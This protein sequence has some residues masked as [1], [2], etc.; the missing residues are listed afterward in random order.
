MLLRDVVATSQRVAETTRR[1]E[2][3]DLLAT[4][5]KR[6]AGDEVE[7]RR[8]HFLS[9]STRQAALALATR[10]CG[11]PPR[12]PRS[13]QPWKS[14]MS[15]T[16][17]ESLTSVRGRGSEQQKTWVAAFLFVRATAAEQDFL[18]GLLLGTYGKARL[19]CDAG[20]AGQGVR[21][22]PGDSAASGDDWPASTMGRVARSVFESGPAGLDPIHCSAF[23]AGAAYACADG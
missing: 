7:N 13:K 19:R 12:R 11:T 10:R 9:G 6:L 23:Q 22:Q 14:A 21:S 20:S 8:G 5:L 4:L 17:W 15:T 2:K 3:I 16:P 1:L 18:K